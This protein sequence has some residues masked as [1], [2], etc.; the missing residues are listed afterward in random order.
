[1]FELSKY[2]RLF[3]NKHVDNP[4]AIVFSDNISWILDMYLL[5]NITNSIVLEN[6]EVRISQL[7]EHLDSFGELD[8]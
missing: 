7:K 4:N 6:L 5:K 1:M 3:N 2:I 8:E